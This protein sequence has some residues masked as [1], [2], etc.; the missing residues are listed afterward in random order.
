MNISGLDS[1]FP[2]FTHVIPR[3][4]T[5]QGL[6]ALFVGVSG[7]FS[8]IH[9][10]HG[11]S[12]VRVEIPDVQSEPVAVA[13]V[14]I[15]LLQQM[16]VAEIAAFVAFHGVVLADDVVVIVVYVQFLVVILVF[17][18]VGRRRENDAGRRLP[19]L[20]AVGEPKVFVESP[21]HADA[22]N[23]LQITSLCVCRFG[24]EQHGSAQTSARDIYRR[25][26]VQ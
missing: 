6:F 3:Q 20:V 26:S 14:V 8:V 16:Q 23:E 12:P 15:H 9:I 2:V 24:R 19:V 1:H 17:E 13:A 18:I 7:I 5:A 22:L 11:Q 10:Q 21:E 4:N 25:R